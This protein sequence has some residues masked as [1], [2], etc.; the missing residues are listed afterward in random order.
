MP[1]Y[2]SGSS[3]FSAALR[4]ASRL[5]F[6]KMKPIFWLRR[7]LMATSSN[8]VTGVPS[9]SYWPLVGLSNMPMMFRRVDL[10]QPDE[11]NTDMKSPPDTS[12]ST[13]RSTGSSTPPIMNERVMPR[14][15]S[16]G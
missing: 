7:R 6:W 10:P 8:S 12:R 13:P 15:L 3:T 1:R 5:K 2:N 16:R 4:R 11:P 9:S 14:S